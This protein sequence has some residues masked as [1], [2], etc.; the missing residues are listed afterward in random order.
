MIGLREM[1]KVRMV[2][3]ANSEAVAMV[4][5]HEAFDG[6]S[7]TKGPAIADRAPIGV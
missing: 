2:R 7:P 1:L 3:K 4:R 5:K 6:R